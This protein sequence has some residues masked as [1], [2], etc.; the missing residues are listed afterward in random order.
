M[1]GSSDGKIHI[2]NVEKGNKVAVL[3]S[4]HSDTIQSIQFNPK[5]MMFA[6]IYK[7]TNPF[8]ITLSMS[9]PFPF[10]STMSFPTHGPSSQ[11]QKEKEL[12]PVP[13]HSLGKKSILS[14]PN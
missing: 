10:V 9:V 3:N 2:W 5:F 7:L 12:P 1:C 8:P 13:L 14:H 11:T 4:E 6:F